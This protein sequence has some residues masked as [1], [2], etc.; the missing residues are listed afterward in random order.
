MKTLTVSLSLPATVKIT[1]QE[2]KELLM[3]KLVDEGVL[4]QSQGADLLG[5]S[6]YELIEL[7]GKH[8]LPIMRYTLKDWEEENRVLKELQAQRRKARSR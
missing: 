8:H 3:L 7:M 4:S 1:E 6:R 5:I 2:A